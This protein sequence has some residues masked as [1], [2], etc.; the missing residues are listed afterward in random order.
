MTFMHQAL[1]KIND[2]ISLATAKQK[3]VFGMLRPQVRHTGNALE[4]C[5]RLHYVNHE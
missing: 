5:S 3:L 4:R 2:R 1:G